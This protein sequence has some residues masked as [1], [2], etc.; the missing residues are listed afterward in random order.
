MQLN[1]RILSDLIIYMKYARYIPD[2]QRR[3]VWPEICSRYASMMIEKY[4]NMEEEINDNM[5]YVLN[6]KIL[7]S[8]RAMQF[9]GPAIIKN[10]S[11]IYNCA[12]LPIDDIRSFSETMFLLLGGTGVGYSVQDHHVAQLPPIKKALKSR[13]FLVGDS[14]EGWADCIKMIM[15]AYFGFNDHLPEFDFSDIRPKGARLVTAGGKAPGP[16]PLRI[17]IAHITAILDRKKMRRNL[18]RWS[19]MTFFVTLPMPY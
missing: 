14:L 6:K 10:N 8:M 2:L 4:P 7:P 17:C 5:Q 19:A 18:L 16:E 1:Q 13:K 12:Y 15:K 3:E 9:A 11:R